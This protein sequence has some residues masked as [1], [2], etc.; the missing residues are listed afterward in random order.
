MN[1]ILVSGLH[2]T[3]TTG[4]YDAVKRAVADHDPP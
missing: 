1:N 3:G 2:K 4:L